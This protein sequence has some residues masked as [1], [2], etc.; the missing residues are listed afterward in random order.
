VVEKTSESAASESANR[1]SKLV[2]WFAVA[3][4]LLAYVGSIGLAEAKRRGAPQIEVKIEG[5]DPRDLLRGQYLQYRIVA[6]GRTDGSIMGAGLAPWQQGDVYRSYACASQESGRT[7]AV[8]VYDGARP[9]E[10]QLDLPVDFIYEAHRYYI[11]QDRGLKLEEAV[12]EGR[13]SVE[14]RVVS[15][16]EVLVQNLLIDGAPIR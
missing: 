11:Q 14:L 1:R 13:A 9:P 7:W 12:R 10:C 16:S 4:P 6:D 15:A 3:L 8:R 2:L 5:Y